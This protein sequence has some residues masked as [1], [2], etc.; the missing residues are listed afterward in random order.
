MYAVNTVDKSTL[1]RWASRIAGSEK[2]QAELNDVRR[3]GRPT[4]AG[5]QASL[6]VLMP[7]PQTINSDLYFQTFKN[8][9][10]RFRR[11]LPDTNIT[12]V[13]LQHDNARPHTH[14]HTH[15]HTRARA[16]LKHRWQL[17]FRNRASYI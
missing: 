14:T 13:L 10:K 7:R 12:E 15:T 4:T 9:Q 6:K 1:S 11:V 16:L 8:L 17:T 2:G 5:T 3:T